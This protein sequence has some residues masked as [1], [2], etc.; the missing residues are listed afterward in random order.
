MKTCPHCA[1]EIQDAAIVCKHCGR[2]LTMAATAKTRWGRILLVVGAL[3]VLAVWALSSASGPR[4]GYL[5][6]S[7]QREAW[8]RKCDAYRQT[9]LSDPV[10]AACAKELNEMVAYAKQ[11]GWN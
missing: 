7:A 4:S 8:H 1:E 10:A 3:L 6:F 2:D 9:P 5:A 11:Q